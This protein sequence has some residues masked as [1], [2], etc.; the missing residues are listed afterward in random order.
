MTRGG[1]Q[2][3]ER[4][5]GVAYE[6]RLV[7]ARGVDESRVRELV[8]RQVEGRSLGVLGEPVVNVLML[9]LAL[10]KQFGQMGPLWP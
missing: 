2:R 1:F 5:H 4:A 7:R 10:D 8:L 6:L 3:D 9:N